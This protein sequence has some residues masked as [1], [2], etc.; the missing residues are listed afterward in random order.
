MVITEKKF[1]NYK[2]KIL[3]KIF[4]FT[5]N[6]KTHKQQNTTR[7]KTKKN[8]CRISLFSVPYIPQINQKLEKAFTKNNVFFHCLSGPKLGNI[9]CAPNKT[10]RNLLDQKGIYQVKCS[11]DPDKCYIGKMRIPIRTKMVQHEADSASQKAINMKSGIS[12]HERECPFGTINWK[13][14]E[15]IESM[16]DT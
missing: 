8:N 11:C 5:I 14:P 7:S 6:A 16:A 13:K 15:V 12:K 4:E 1:N 2:P 3:N 9:L 10:K